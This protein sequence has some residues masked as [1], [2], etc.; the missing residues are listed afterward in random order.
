MT[1][2]EMAGE[3]RRSCL[4]LQERMGLLRRALRTEEDILTAQQL[5]QR[6]AELTAL[7]RE[8]REIALHLEHYY[9]RRYRTHGK[10]SF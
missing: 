10:F 4:L 7:Y 8:G 3:Y 1:L 6:L 5:R 9:D 2:Q